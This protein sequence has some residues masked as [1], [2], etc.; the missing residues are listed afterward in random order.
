MTPD[1]LVFI[2]HKLFILDVFLLAAIAWVLG[3][4]LFYKTVPQL[5][6]KPSPY[7]GI[8]TAGFTKAEWIGSAIV[9]CF[10][11]ASVW[12]PFFID[13]ESATQTPQVPPLVT[14][15]LMF[16]GLCVQFVF[17]CLILI[18][19]LSTKTNVL[20]AF[21]LRN[22]N[23]GKTA[24]YALAGFILSIIMLLIISAGGW[25]ENLSSKIFGETPAQ[26]AVQAFS[27]ASDPLMQIVLILAAV[28]FAPICEE[29]LFRG[30]LYT[31]TKK[32]TG[33]IFSVIITSVIFSAIHGSATSF[34][35][36]CIV[37]LILTITYELSG[38]LW[39]NIG[40]HAAFN[41][42]SVAA[43]QLSQG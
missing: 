1:T 35:P 33:V 26:A 15:V 13:T 10:F 4:L 32:Y 7:E 42:F 30:F 24:F 20:D 2:D 22:V 27:D 17:P 9:I 11:S 37:G 8:S 25:Y 43:M 38:S 19:I 36:L 28:V 40:I 21:G 18:I 16:A 14:A 6:E 5:S 29:I 41:L 23:W 31:A 39:T 12:L 34:L 3:T